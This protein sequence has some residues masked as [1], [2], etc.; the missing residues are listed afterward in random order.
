IKALSVGASAEVG[1]VWSSGQ[2]IGGG[3]LK[4]SYTFFTSLS[5]AFG[6]RRVRWPAAAA[7][8]PCST[9]RRRASCR[10]GAPAPSGRKRSLSWWKY[11]A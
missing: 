9:R 1:N 7:R 6:R 2:Q 11:L 10:A 3:A 8:R 5:T 4:Q